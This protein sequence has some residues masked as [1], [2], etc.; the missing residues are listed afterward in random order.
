MKQ[1]SAECSESKRRKKPLCN[2]KSSNGNNSYSKSSNGN[3]SYSKSSSNGSSSSSVNSVNSRRRHR[4][5]H[6]FLRPRSARLRHLPLRAHQ[7]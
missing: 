7:R 4:Q 3:N 1:R 2:S 5:R 6:G